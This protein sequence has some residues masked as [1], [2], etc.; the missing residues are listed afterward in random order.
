MSAMDHNATHA[1]KRV[2]MAADRMRKGEWTVGNQ[3]LNTGMAPSI[4]LY[5]AIKTYITIKCIF[6]NV[7]NNPVDNII[8]KGV[9]VCAKLIKRGPY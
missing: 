1:T 9:C 5:I 7:F 2:N 3:R 4:L 8:G 6:F